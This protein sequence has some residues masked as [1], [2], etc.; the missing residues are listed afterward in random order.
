MLQVAHEDG[1]LQLW[2]RALHVF[3]EASRVREFA[4]V[5]G[6]DSGGRP[7]EGNEKLQALGALMDASHKS[8][9]QLFGCS[10]VELDDLVAVG[11]VG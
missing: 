4:R 8:C 6:K 9:S 5:C 3:Q 1:G 11:K 7:E 10:C 2:G